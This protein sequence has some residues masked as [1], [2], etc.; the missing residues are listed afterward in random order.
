VWPVDVS[1]IDREA[2]MPEPTRRKVACEDAEAISARLA[3]L[4]KERAEAM[5][6]KDE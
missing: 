3:E 6:R 2:E 5:N 1:C 4:A